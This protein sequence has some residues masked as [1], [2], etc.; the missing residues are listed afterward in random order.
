MGLFIKEGTKKEPT[1]NQMKGGNTLFSLF[2]VVFIPCSK[3]DLV[4][5]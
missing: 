3:V 1:V 4:I 2:R 5:H